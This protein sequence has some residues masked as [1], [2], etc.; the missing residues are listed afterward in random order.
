MVGQDTNNQTH[1]SE[2]WLS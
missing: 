2:L 1:C